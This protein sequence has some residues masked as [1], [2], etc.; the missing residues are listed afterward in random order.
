MKKYKLIKRAIPYY[1]QKGSGFFKRIK[2]YAKDRDRSVFGYL[3]FKIKSTLFQ[4]LALN[5]PLNSVRVQLHRWRGVQIGNG[6][7]IGKK[8][9]IDNLYPDYVILEDNAHLHMESMIIAHFNPAIHFSP[10]FEA[11]ANPVI[12][13][14]EAIVGIRAV[15]MPGVTIGNHAMVMAGTVVTKNIPAYSLVQGNPSKIVI[16]F[17]HLL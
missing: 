5:C 2:Q 15:I 6:V 4:S 14:K 10:V 1:N 8:V 11:I 16:N 7:Y 12:V 13:K 9:F 3:W 17:K